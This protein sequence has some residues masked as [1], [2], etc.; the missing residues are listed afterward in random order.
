MPSA[1]RVDESKCLS[2]V[3][4][5]LSVPGVSGAERPVADEIM[6]MLHA[7]GVPKGSM[8]ID[9]ANRRMKMPRMTCGNLI[10]TL[11]GD[12]RSRRMF[13]AHMDTVTLVE[14][15]KPVRRGRRIVSATDTALGADDRAGVGALVSGLRTVL[16]RGLD[17]PPLTLVFTV[18]EEMGL[19]GARYIDR[20]ILGRVQCAFNF[21]GSGPREFNL[22][23][24]SSDHFRIEVTGK[25]SH[26]GGA[27]ELGVSAVAA[28]S[29]AIADLK[30][31]GWFGKVVKGRRHGTSNIGSFVAESPTNIVSPR[32]VLE[33][34][35][36]SH[37]D[38]FLNKITSNF[39]RAFERAC[40]RTRSA[41]G[42]RAKASF[43]SERI[44]T[45]F[46]LK[47]SDPVV[48][49]GVK[50]AEAAGLEVEM[51]VGGGGLD[52]NYFNG[53]GVPTLTLGAG[54]HGAHTVTEHLDIKEHM[55]G[56]R[57]AAAL[58]TV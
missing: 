19:L 44:Y 41:D 32:A 31:N 13:S 21:D 51:S 17:H 11:G 12:R 5:L 34:E 36:R 39:K 18:G 29:A 35:S 45:A 53:Y 14:G 16:E 52:A 48:K 2:T 27:P 33:G 26:A 54:A 23:A 30:D 42:H 38:P 24:P 8:K 57:M 10:V 49:L 47:A 25:A 4:K 40:R 46:R 9:H 20:K 37:W 15:V 7:A 50:A 56:C 1:I 3:M 28:A 55:A 6:R 43:K 58:M 22:G